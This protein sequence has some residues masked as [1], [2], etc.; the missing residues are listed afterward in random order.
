M[1]NLTHS[2]N[3]PFF[4]LYDYFSYFNL[5]INYTY[6]ALDAF[7]KLLPF[8]GQYTEVKLSGRHTSLALW[9]LSYYLTEVYTHRNDIKRVTLPT[10]LYN[11]YFVM[12]IFLEFIDLKERSE[13]VYDSR[14][15]TSQ[16]LNKNAEEIQFFIAKVIDANNNIIF[17]KN[18]LFAPKELVRNLN[19]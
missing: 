5:I 14:F 19:Y 17:T 7:V 3:K 6:Y 16:F 4:S 15:F 9:E 8:Q 1:L 11:S 18:N 2:P 10:G 12:E 13:K